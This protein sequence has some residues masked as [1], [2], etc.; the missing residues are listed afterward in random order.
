MLWDIQR[1]GDI[2]FPKRWAD[3]VESRDCRLLGQIQDPGR[4]RHH[5]GNRDTTVGGDAVVPLPIGSVGGSRTGR[6]H[7]NPRS[8]EIP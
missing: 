4:A 6:G 8:T 1:T 7:G 5:G 3:A 2:F